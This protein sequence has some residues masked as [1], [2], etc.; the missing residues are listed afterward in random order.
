MQLKRQR[1]SQ[2]TPE[3]EA[4][5][6]ELRQ[7]GVS[8]KEIE[9]QTGVGQGT[10][11]AWCRALGIKLSGEQRSKNNPKRLL[12]HEQ[13]LQLLEDRKT[14]MT[15]EEVA[16]KYGVKEG[17]VKTIQKR[18]GFVIPM[19][20]R[21]AN[22]RK[23]LVAVNPNYMDDMRRL[24]TSEVIRARSE[25][26]RARYARDPELRALKGRQSKDWWRREGP[27]SKYTWEQVRMAASDANMTMLRDAVGSLDSYETPV[28]CHCGL[29]FSCRTYDVIYG[30][31][32][33]CGCTKSKP[34]NDLTQWIINQGLEVQSND[35]QIIKPFELDIVVPALKVAIEY[36]GL[37]WH[38][39]DK[40]P[41]RKYHY[42]KM[43]MAEAAGYR[44]V[45]IFADEWLEREAAVR[46]YL[47]SILRLPPE[48][49][50]GAR[51][52]DIQEVDWGVA[53]EFL[54]TWHIQGAGAP[55]QVNLALSVQGDTWAIASFRLTS[56]SRRGVAEDGV[57][58][59]TRYC[60]RP[61][62]VVVGGFAKVMAHFAKTNAVRTVFTY[63]DRRWSQGA[64]YRTSNFVQ[65]ATVPPSYSYFKKNSE[66]PRFHKS[67]FRKSAIGAT[68]NETEWEVMKRNGYD[69]IWDCGLIKW[70]W[71]P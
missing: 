16:A 26:I 27:D 43:K 67:K 1:K 33:S 62:T 37:T 71:T 14:G 31:I 23:G 57:W 35:R 5:V 69:R 39:E 60:V 20:L 52:L 59:L 18:H 29:V 58:E 32:Q 7:R 2:Y 34:Q 55:A 68:A 28:Q 22:A 66:S 63:S 10:V 54:G 65:A 53:S 6:F 45:T 30:K 12:T 21:Q 15:R 17:T 9:I 24:Q 13:E 36:C 8:L 44:L 25:A 11:R 49:K 50:F 4:K 40:R 46:G 19:E 41:D 51:E 48:R 3:Q 61:G 47:G 56:S 38:G 42:N 64:L 70:V